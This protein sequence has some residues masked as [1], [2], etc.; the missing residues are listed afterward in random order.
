MLKLNAFW[1]VGAGV[2]SL[3]AL[4]AGCAA[5]TTDES[6][7]DGDVGNISGSPGV[8]ANA[9]AGPTAS[10]GP[11]SSASGSPSSGGSTTTTTTGGMA[12]SSM[13]GTVSGGTTSG[14][15]VFG[16]TAPMA[17]TV[18]G[19]T[20]PMAGTTA[21]G[22]TAAG[23]SAA[24]TSAAG[25]TASEGVTC[26]AAFAVGTD[27]FVRAP[28]TS[29]CWHGYAYASGDSGSTVTPESFET[30]G[31]GCT[32]HVTGTVGAANADNNYAGY[33]VVGFNISQASGGGTVETTTPS[34]SSLTM[35]FTK[36]SGPDL[37]VQLQSGSTT[38]CASVTS[39]P[40]TVA[41]TD[42]NTECWEGGAGTAYAMQPIDA[43]QLSLPGAETATP[44]D[45]TLVSAADQ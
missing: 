39:S 3:V 40:A 9:G 4:I 17:G 12:G 20:A 31:S 25:A 29:G 27:G 23:T 13:G 24:G 32:L 16:G 15:S 18:S 33:V 22:T 45:V 34:G 28:G 5:Q 26:D 2:G 21:A 11:A 1:F 8:T 41:Y 38:W 35:T 14:G 19:G 30:C 10:G 43:V 36:V 42:F 37:R 7:K 6:R 44:F